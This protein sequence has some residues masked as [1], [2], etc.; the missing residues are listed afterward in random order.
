[1]QPHLAAARGNLRRPIATATRRDTARRF[2]PAYLTTMMW[3]NRKRRVGAFLDDGSELEG[4]YTCSGTVMLDAKFRGELTARDTLI[5]GEHGVVEAT[6][7]ATN[8][9]VRGTIVGNV[10]AA[11]SIELK[12]TARVTGDVDAPRIVMEPGAVLD[13]RC[14]MTVNEPVE[15]LLPTAVVVAIK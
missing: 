5:V 4:R 9:V 3:G 8:V 1:L 6:V 14:R 7:R 12:A 13:G 15:V 10:T 2:V 11:E